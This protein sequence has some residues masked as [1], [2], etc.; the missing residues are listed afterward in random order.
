M[1]LAVLRHYRAADTPVAV[2][3]DAQRA[4]QQVSLSTLGALEACQAGEQSIII[5]GTASTRVVAGRMITL[6]DG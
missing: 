4:E 2:V 3:R 6:D 5:V 1:V